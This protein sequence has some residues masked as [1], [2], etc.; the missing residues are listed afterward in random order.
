MVKLH[1]GVH[2]RRL[3]ALAAGALLMLVAASAATAQ[4][5]GSAHDF[6]GAT[7]WNTTGEICVVCHA[8]HNGNT[9]VADA[10]LWNHAVTAA[11]YTLYESGTL[12]ATVGQPT[13]ASK[14]CL[15]CHDGTVAVDN[16][17]G[18]TGGT[19]FVDAAFQVGT[20]LGDDHPISFT[21][22]TALATA[23]GDLADPST[24]LSTLGGTIAADMLINDVMHCSSC[25]DV[26]NQ[27]GE[28]HL[29]KLDNGGSALCLTCHTK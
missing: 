1:P 17:G 4:I 16:F 21:Y 5:T 11:T 6:S 12:D 2:R 10:P 7:S 19:N 14:L 24:A 29:L 20:A 8:P 27:Y 25:H 28:A 9:S 3:A 26:H 22:N 15:S 23:D 13:G 18:E